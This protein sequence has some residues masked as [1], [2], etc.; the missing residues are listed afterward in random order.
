MRCLML[1]VF[2]EFRNIFFHRIASNS[3]LTNQM[4]VWQQWRS[5]NEAEE[6]MP[7]EMNLLR[8]V[9]VLYINFPTVKKTSVTNDVTVWPLLNKFSAAILSHNWPLCFPLHVSSLKKMFTPIGG[10]KK[11]KYFQGE[12]PSII[13]F[14]T[15][16]ALNK[17]AMFEIESTLKFLLLWT[18]KQILLLS[19][20]GNVIEMFEAEH[21]KVS[22]DRLH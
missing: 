1:K 7:P 20:S 16:H 3:D 14:R 19:L 17:I 5:Q 8:F 21:N 9:L 11:W 6:T 10:S 22:N 13:F 4:L 15:R 18:A 2:T 12:L